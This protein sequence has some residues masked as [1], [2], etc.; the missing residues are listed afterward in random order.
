MLNPATNGVILYT[1]PVGFNYGTQYAWTTW[2]ISP[3][4][5]T[6]IPTD[7]RL[8]TF[9]APASIYNPDDSATDQI[10]LFG[11]DELIDPP[12]ELYSFL[13]QCRE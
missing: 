2:I 6:G 11:W 9:A 5:A 7:A 12:C 8:I 3:E 10:W 1:L 13:E 4:G